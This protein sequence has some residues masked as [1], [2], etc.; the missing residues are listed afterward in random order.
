VR[1][2]VS[3]FCVPFITFRKAELSLCLINMPWCSREWIYCCRHSNSYSYD[4]CNAFVLQFLYPKG[5][6]TS[7]PIGCRVVW[8]SKPDWTWWW[9]KSSSPFI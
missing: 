3:T 6:E 5:K 8:I 4:C 9:R 1:W 2:I 7:Y